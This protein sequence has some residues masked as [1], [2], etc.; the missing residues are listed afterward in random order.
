MQT[1]LAITLS[2]LM[3]FSYLGA[4]LGEHARN[5]QRLGVGHVHM[6]ISCSPGVSRNFDIALALLHN[7]W[8]PRALAAFDQITQADPECAMAYWGAAMT[9]NHP[10]WDA[11]TP[12]DEQNR[13]FNLRA[14]AASM[15]SHSSARTLR[16]D[17]AGDE[18][19]GP[20]PGAV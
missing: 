17:A 1:I 9:Y 20:G 15:P 16:D 14:V 3:V 5:L 2:L 13:R 4:V 11:P 18:Q 7:F 10:F 6:D 19:P 8:Y 12:A